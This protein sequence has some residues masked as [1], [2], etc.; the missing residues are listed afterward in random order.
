MYREYLVVKERKG[1]VASTYYYHRGGAREMNRKSVDVA[2][3]LYLLEL[4]IVDKNQVVECTY[5]RIS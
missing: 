4:V 1:T 2:L 3:I 5:S